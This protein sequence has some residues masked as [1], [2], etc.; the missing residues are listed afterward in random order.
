MTKQSIAC[1]GGFEVF[2]A[3]GFDVYEARDAR[4]AEEVFK[5]IRRDYSL[6]LV[7]ERFSEKMDLTEFRGE[8]TPLLIELPDEAGGTGAGRKR[9][10]ELISKA[11]GIAMKEVE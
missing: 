4:E 1:I 11:S 7:A 8:K 6:V 3:I 9:I 2:K 5:R 10:A